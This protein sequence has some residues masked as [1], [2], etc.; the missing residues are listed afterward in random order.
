[1]PRP[2]PSPSPPHRPVLSPACREELATPFRKPIVAPPGRQMV[3][4]LREAR[5]PSRGRRPER[6]E[7]LAGGV[8]ALRFT[9]DA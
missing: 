8:L 4:D 9:P 7:A 6:V 5:R 1:M 2:R 3:P